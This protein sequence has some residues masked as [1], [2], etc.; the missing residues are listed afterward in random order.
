MDNKFPE[1]QEDE[2]HSVTLDIA[3]TYLYISLS[4]HS[5]VCLPICLAS[6]WFNTVKEED[7]LQGYALDLGP[8]IV[9]LWIINILSVSD[10]LDPK[11]L[12]LNL[13]VF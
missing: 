1:N 3:K 13:L 9:S 12:I 4:V 7:E 8:T 2:R 5:S 6:S 10:D 11:S